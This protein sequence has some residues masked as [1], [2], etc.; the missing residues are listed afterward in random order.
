[1]ARVAIA[2]FCGMTPE[3]QEAGTGKPIPPEVTTVLTSL[4]ALATQCTAFEAENRP[5]A[6]EIIEWLEDLQSMTAELPVSLLSPAHR[7][8]ESELDMSDYPMIKWEA[9]VETGGGS[10][11]SS[12]S[13][14]SDNGAHLDDNSG[15]IKQVHVGVGSGS[16]GSARVTHTPFLDTNRPTPFSE[17]AI[18]SLPPAVQPQ[19]A[20][21]SMMSPPPAVIPSASPMFRGNSSG[22]IRE[23]WLLR[24]NTVGFMSWSNYW[25]Q[26]TATQFRYS[27]V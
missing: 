14:F 10:N 17:T 23:G 7:Q 27:I 18:R 21:A 3:E 5:I 4:T 15:S 22:V 13:S 25:C 26:L 8:E 16:I 1:M 12:C 19:P 6:A 2:S 20:T 11:R 24:K 9:S